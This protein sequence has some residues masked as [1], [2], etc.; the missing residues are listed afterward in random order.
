MNISF[1]LEHKNLFNGKK[2]QMMTAVDEKTVRQQGLEILEWQIYKPPKEKNKIIVDMGANIGMASLYL[3]Q[4]A[5]TVHSIEPS[6]SIYECLVENTKGMNIITHNVAIHGVEGYKELISVD[7]NPP[8][9]FYPNDSGGQKTKAKEVVKC[10]T[11]EQFMTDNKIKHIDL[12]KIDVE[13]AE[14]EIFMS[15][16]F[17]KMAPKID[18]IVGESHFVKDTGAFPQAIPEILKLYGFKT[19]FIKTPLKN[20]TQELYYTDNKSGFTRSIGT[21]FYTEFIATKK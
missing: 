10:I 2:F 20:Y 7:D 3:S 14:Y 5:D 12:L 1:S 8:Q 9:G 13:G 19:R 6:R 17:E 21:S 4:F 11:I 16:A 15:D 18:A